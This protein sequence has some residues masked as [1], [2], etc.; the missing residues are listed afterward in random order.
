MSQSG[1]TIQTKIFGVLRRLH[2]PQSAYDILGELREG[3]PKIAPPTVYRALTALMDKGLVHR[4]ES[5][6]AYFACQHHENCQAAVMSICDDCGSVE[7]NLAPELLRKLSRISAQ[8]GFTPKRHIVEI[9][10]VCA[11]CMTH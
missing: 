2:T 8:S 9:H 5:T 4:L 11:S 10:G 7:E 3:N 6:K 1:K